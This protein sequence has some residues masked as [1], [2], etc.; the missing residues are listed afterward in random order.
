[1]KF[2]NTWSWF[3]SLLLLCSTYGWCVE[4]EEVLTSDD[5]VIDIPIEYEQ[6]I[7][8]AL[9]YL[10]DKQQ[11][12]GSWVGGRYGRNVGEVSLALMS[13]MSLGNLPGEGKYGHVVAKGLDWILSKVQ[14]SGLIRSDKKAPAMYGHAL[15]TLMLS[16]VWGQTRRED[17]GSALNKAVG[18][19]LRCQGP[20]GGWG[21]KS[22]PKD[23]DTS[24]CVM[25]LFALKSAHEAGIYVP[26]SVI[27]K[28]LSLIKTRY[29]EKERAFGYSS[30]SF[31]ARHIGSSAA[32]ACIM[33]ICQEPDGRYLS[34]PLERLIEEM[35]SQSIKGHAYY[36]M[37]YGSVAS[38][39]AGPQYYKR[40]LKA[41][42]KL[43]LKAPE[44][45]W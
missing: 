5:V 9:Q 14:P 1:M 22:V 15:A 2:M 4:N 18:L 37:Y 35:E 24:V 40:W 31:S 34:P 6:A 19:I 23:G 43:C 25:Q 45:Q 13:F 27:E 20:K 8:K 36:F 41:Q 7:S 44:K 16:E 26:I 21:Y 28:S 11:S 32:G 12:D 17:V 39:I 30:K 10:S 38:Y 42:K 29:N 3:L 33:Q